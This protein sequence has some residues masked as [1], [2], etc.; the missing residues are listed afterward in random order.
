MTKDWLRQKSAKKL[1]L[2]LGCLLFFLA[3]SLSF[4]TSTAISL[5]TFGN[6]GRQL[7]TDT[8][9]GYKA[10]SGGFLLGLDYRTES[11]NMIGT[12]WGASNSIIHDNSN[13]NHTTKIRGYHGMFYGGNRF[14]AN[15]FMEWALSG[16]M[17]KNKG[18]RI[19]SSGSTNLSNFA[20]YKVLQTSFKMSFGKHLN[21]GDSFRFSPLMSLQ[22]SFTRQPQY[23]ETGNIATLRVTVQQKIQSL[24]PSLGVK[25]SSPAEDW[26]WWLIGS[27]ELKAMIAYDVIST[28]RKTISNFVIGGSDFTILNSP[29]RASLKL[30]AIFSFEMFQHLFLDL[31]YNYELRHRF[32]DHAGMLKVKYVF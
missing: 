18:T 27:R 15:K 26:A 6:L 1:G 19:V 17:N 20:N 13:N 24:T 3:P 9:S 28:G 5:G 25:F 10:K 4:A 32:M 23:T 30:G 12:A 11:N 14:T 31:N 7:S 29:R 22:Y 2:L 16:T 21:V 8:N